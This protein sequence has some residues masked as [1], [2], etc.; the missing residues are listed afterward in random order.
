MVVNDKKIVKANGVQNTL[1][2]K[3]IHHEIYKLS[4]DVRKQF[5]KKQ[6]A[7]GSQMGV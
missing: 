7:I 3:D 6:V 2:K 4:L 1:V 5:R